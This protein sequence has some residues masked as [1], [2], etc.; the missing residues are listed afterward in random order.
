M[1]FRT[2][3]RAVVEGS[4]RLVSAAYYVCG[5]GAGRYLA[6]YVAEGVLPQ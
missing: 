5:P 1:K 2:T 4:A 6:Y 3:R